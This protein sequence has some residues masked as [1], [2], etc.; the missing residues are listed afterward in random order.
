[1]LED[2]MKEALKDM[3][4]FDPSKF[5]QVFQKA[6]ELI[7]TDSRFN[8]TVEGNRLSTL[9]YKLTLYCQLKLATMTHLPH[10]FGLLLVLGVVGYAWRVK[11]RQRYFAAR[12]REITAFVLKELQAKKNSHR[13]GEQAEPFVIDIELRDGFFP[14]GSYTKKDNAE[15]WKRVVHNIHSH[16]SVLEVPRLIYGT[17]HTTWEWTGTWSMPTT[18]TTLGTENSYAPR[19]VE[20]RHAE[21]FPPR[22]FQRLA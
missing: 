11:N 13:V 12:A 6:V 15:L 9:G 3:K 17:Q 1:M 20:V 2:E 21:L 7:K 19:S 8:I 18:S 5:A 22:T 16:P 10:L 4:E 14:E